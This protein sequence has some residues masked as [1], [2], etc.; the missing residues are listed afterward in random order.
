MDVCL[1]GV[2]EKTSLLL[3]DD[4]DIVIGLLAELGIKRLIL[5]NGSDKLTNWSSLS[6]CMDCALSSVEG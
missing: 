4:G 3:D 5:A 2:G 6:Q 1:G